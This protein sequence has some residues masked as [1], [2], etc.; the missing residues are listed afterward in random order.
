MTGSLYFDPSRNIFIKHVRVIE[1]ESESADD[2]DLSVVEKAKEEYSTDLV[3][4]NLIAERVWTNATGQK[5]T[6]A[7][8]KVEA[9]IGKFRRADGREFDYEISKFSDPDRKLISDAL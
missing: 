1:F 9:G 5:M 4:A 8:F 6:A 2:D 3:S 7:L